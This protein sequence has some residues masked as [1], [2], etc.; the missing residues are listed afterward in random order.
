MSGINGN[1][2]FTFPVNYRLNSSRGSL[3]HTNWTLLKHCE[4][5]PNIETV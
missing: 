4:W 5:D 1:K 3:F 2:T